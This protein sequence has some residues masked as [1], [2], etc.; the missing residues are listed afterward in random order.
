MSRLTVRLTLML[1]LA[2]CLLLALGAPAVSA[3][4][5]APRFKRLKVSIWPEYDASRVLVLYE[6]ELADGVPLPAALRFALPQGAEIASACAIDENG[7]HIA[8]TPQ[9]QGG[10]NP[11][12]TY[13]TSKR[14]THVDFYYQPIEGAG[15]RDIAYTVRA[16]G[17][18]EV[19]EVEVQKPLRAS[20]FA[21]APAASASRTDSKGFQYQRFDYTNV[22]VGAEFTYKI[23]YEKPDAEPSV[24]PQGSPAAGPSV[25]GEY[26]LPLVVFGLGATV[27]GTLFYVRGRRPARQ[28]RPVAGARRGKRAAASPSPAAA[29]Q[30]YCTK[31]GARIRAGATF[32][33]GCGRPLRRSI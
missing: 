6:G 23:T 12:V 32:C 8:A 9:Q 20:N 3:Q 2:V 28:P 16:P 5:A 13:S 27:L 15:L 18:V 22:A 11:S 30:A 25:G 7:Q 17:A 1:G 19:L 26:G 24:P 4:E 29:A 31:C 21:L 10:D 33:T 14:A